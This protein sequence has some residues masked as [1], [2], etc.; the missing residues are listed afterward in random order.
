[1]TDIYE[2]LSD[3]YD[4]MQ[5]STK[6]IFRGLWDGYRITIQN[7]YMELWLNATANF[8]QAMHP[9][10][11]RVWMPLTSYSD[12]QAYT[13]FTDLISIPK[14]VDRYYS[15]TIEYSEGT[16]YTIIDG[17]VHFSDSSKN[18]QTYWAPVL[19][20]KNTFFDNWGYSG[21]RCYGE[22]IAEV[23]KAVEYGIKFGSNKKIM[24][25]TISAI[26]G[27]PLAFV[28][29]TVNSVTDNGDYYSIEIGENNRM[30]KV[31]KSLI[32]SDTMV[33][34]GDV[35]ERFQP[36]IDGKVTITESYGYTYNNRV[37]AALYKTATT[38]E[39][40]DGSTV[41]PDDYIAI[42]D[43]WAGKTEYGVVSDYDADTNTI[44][45]NKPMYLNHDADAQVMIRVIAK[46]T[47]PTTIAVSVK[48][49]AGLSDDMKK[50]IN[51][52]YAA[53]QNP[54]LN[55]QDISYT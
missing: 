16:D 50:N 45:L 52:Y 14:L 30:H 26:A 9:Y 51:N 28:A 38:L 20:F 40:V 15:P 36:L 29:G 8:I 7:L 11:V 35:V 3:Y 23:A 48:S 55:W 47:G 31:Y 42:A 24:T 34:V 37:Q 46:T 19:Y 1:M 53:V 12:T 18:G 43:I 27:Y 49:H 54:A 32:D 4:L 2:L 10:M 44:T 22:N 17:S 6:N 39:I 25:W 41:A 13:V 21:F 33:G 5:D